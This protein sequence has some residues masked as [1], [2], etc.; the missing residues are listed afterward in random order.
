MKR[1]ALGKGL[2]ALIPAATDSDEGIVTSDLSGQ[3][4]IL[5]IPVERIAASPFQSRQAFD[6][7]KLAELAESIKERGVIQPVVVR[8]VNDT[9]ELIAGE[10]R[11]K[12]VQ[13]L[14]RPTIPAVIVESVDN[15][16]AM[17]LALIENLQREDLNPIEEASGY[18]RLITECNLSQADVAARVGRDRSSV[19]NTIRLLSLP[20]ELQDMLIDGSISAGHARALLAVPDNSEKIALAY[21]VAKEDL[22]VRQ[23]EHLVYADKTIRKPRTPRPRSAQI[24]SVEE[25]L[26]RKLA[27]KVTITQKR[28]GGKITIEY[29]SVDEL[30]R[31]LEFFGVMEGF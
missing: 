5:E 27:T 23:L 6:P 15:E 7:G 1:L 10:R 28:K 30:N 31:L 16:T 8:A 4:A 3:R 18:H 13:K 19:A 25:S 22:S 9:Y 17:E 14:N 11:L 20:G 21:R 24:A 2:E 12:A 29:Y 26:K